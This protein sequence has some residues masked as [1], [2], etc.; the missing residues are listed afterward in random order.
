VRLSQYTDYALRTLFYLGLSPGRW[1]SI[2]DIARSYGISSH[3]LAKIAQEL[4]R[5][6]WIDTRRGRG[7]G[8]RLA[9]PAEQIRVGEIV[10]HTER[11]FGLVEC[12]D[13]V[14][15]RCPISASCPIRGAFARAEEAFL[16]ELDGVTI[17]QLVQQPGS[18]PVLLQIAG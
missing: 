12:W 6:D 3:H 17:A 2:K 5:Q 1:I 14:T 18:V 8:I 16:C 4:A 9:K 11:G 7:G 15:N 10:R 13:P